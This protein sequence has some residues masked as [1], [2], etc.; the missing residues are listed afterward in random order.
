VTG[1]ATRIG[2]TVRRTAQPWSASVRAVL[3][4]LER[5]GVSGVPRALGLD[6]LGR[7]T[8]SY[9][10]GD[11]WD[12]P[13]PELVWRESTLIAVAA[14]L[15][16]LHDATLDFEPPEDACWML[17]MPADLPAEVVCHNDFAPYNVAFDD[18]GPVGVI[19]W[20]TAAPGA[21]AW[22]VAY[23][24]YRFVPLS[25][26][27]PVELREASAQARRLAMFCDA[28][29]LGSADRAILLATVARRVEHLRDLILSEAAKGSPVFASH[30]ADG[31]VDGYEADLEY[32]R[33]SAVALAE[34]L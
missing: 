25:P 31:H 17:A 2:D 32:V 29:G 30:L 33:A 16:G 6:A 14:L 4:H 13:M 34:W 28:Y 5:A 10:A 7:E 9:V 15:R 26:D 12:Y 11:V 24:A 3:L 21:R 20:E 23:A 27:A 1:D 18:H 22:D 19:D 8:S